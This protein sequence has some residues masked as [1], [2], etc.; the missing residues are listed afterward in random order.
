MTQYYLNPSFVGLKMPIY[1]MNIISSLI[2]AR[3]TVHL[4]EFLC[5]CI[6]QLDLFIYVL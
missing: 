2:Y 1:E 3:Q 5:V 4:F 6:M